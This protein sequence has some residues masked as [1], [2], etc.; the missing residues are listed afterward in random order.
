MKART[1]RHISLHLAATLVA[2]CAG[3]LRAA[4]I[5]IDTHTF[6][7]PDGFT[8]ERVTSTDQAPR[9]VSAA[10]DDRGR[11][12]V[13][14]SSG[15]NEKPS[16]QL[17]NPKARILRLEDTN[18]DGV[19]DTST[20]FADR[21]MFPQGC[22]WHD[23]SVYVAGP[24]SIWK[25]TDTD[26][27]GIADKREEWFKGG[28]LT[29]CA[30]DI[31]GPYLGPDGYIYW[32]KG[33]FDEQT[34]TLGN[35][36]VLKD[37]AAHIYRA[38]PDGSDLDVVMTGGMDNPVGVAFTAEGEVVFT[39]TFI[40]FSQPGFRDGIG[41]ASY[42]ALFGKENSALDDGRVKRPSPDLTHPFV[43]F[44]AG[45]PSGLCRY[46][47]ST[48]G[49][50]YR[51]NLFASLFNLRKI[52]RHKLRPS[53]ATY[54][55]TD[56]D[57]VVSDNMDFH[58]TDVL[59]DPDG[60]LL[61][62]DTGGWYKLCCPSSQIAKADV[63]G[64]IYRV[65]K[66]GAPRPT[67]PSG[68]R[69]A[70]A[71]LSVAWLV[72]SFYDIRPVVRAKA[73]D[74]LA[75]RGDTAI[76][77]LAMVIKYSQNLGLVQ[78]AA[79]T[80]G[81]IRTPSAAAAMWENLGNTN[82][83]TETF[84]DARR[85]TV[86]KVIAQNRWEPGDAMTRFA[87][88]IHLACSTPTVRRAAAELAGRLGA[89]NH[90][91]SLLRAAAEWGIDE[92][93]RRAA[94]LALIEIN[95]PDVLRGVIER[96]YKGTR[97]TGKSQ[98]LSVADTMNSSL[99]SAVLTALD[100]MDK[101]GLKP[102]EVIPFLTATNRVLRDT[103]AWITRRHPDW[104]ASL[105]GFLGERLRQQDLS[106][107]ERTEL[108][109][110]LA[111]F[112]KSPAV[113]ELLA[114]TLART[115]TSAR[116]RLDTLRA[117]GQ[118]GLKETPAAWRNGVAAALTNAER[119]VVREAVSTVRSFTI[120]KEERA[121]IVELLLAIGTDRTLE[122]DM[123][124]EA[125]AAVPG[126]VAEP[127]EE[128][129][130]FVLSN[131]H[132]T[133]PVNTRGTAASVLAKARLRIEQQR[134]LAGAMTE[135][136]PL[137]MTKLLALF[138]KST[139]LQLGLQLVTAL[140]QARPAGLRADVVRAAL[141]SFPPQVQERAK[142]LLNKLNADAGKQ[143]THLEALLTEVRGKGDV[144]RGQAIFNSAKAACS[145][146]HAI[147]YQGGKLG[148]DLTRISE[149]RGERDLLEA[150]VF[151]SASF[152]RSYEPMV[153]AM[154]DGEE[155]SG[156]LRREDSSEVLL[157]TGP[158]AEMRIARTDIKEMRPGTVSVMPQGLDEQLSRQELADLLAFLRN[159]KWGA[160]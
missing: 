21:V 138:E 84:H 23:G 132:A 123:R 101:G 95:R 38:K 2:V 45:A 43:Q 40:D 18:G 6:T 10:F 31:H 134:T 11:L 100:Q 120:P 58:P 94:T 116:A 111:A 140:Q 107:S 76:P 53:G 87:I 46:Q 158:T 19:F 70:F 122:S 26:G 131:L 20:V 27:D 151:P 7:V 60:S 28:T 126:G 32:T 56:S 24:P 109:R 154:K 104:A 25:F 3:S 72:D 55:S 105:A 145:A 57:F 156:V 41:H 139:D 62:I 144:R 50:D 89:T 52:T 152:V 65:R 102:D 42:G 98:E 33:A 117:M 35:G 108:Q 82:Q 146:C 44:G 157:A 142:E 47:S 86:F 59:E 17:K 16:E 51:D 129:F 118:A 69:I 93:V 124:L 39:S 149:V 112:A 34:H 135:V 63:L 75:R 67:D 79:Q 121:P 1:I 141:A 13:T 136:S 143:Q 125:L 92:T 74:E 103:A 160:Q 14:D 106:E 49:E 153:V 68:L 148:P 96:E 8:I 37:R 147:G 12:Y 78:R 48:F 30:N 61:I 110:Q 155:H 77:V 133:H 73:A 54:A 29:G 66:A 4:E 9:P 5:R 88:D 91:S 97:S 137:E 119:A 83:L 113:Q 36:R 128:L 81:R 115:E 80:L 99:R 159:T 130:R 64:G 15:S 90:T 22:L 114:T 150:I 127:S 85:A 71:K